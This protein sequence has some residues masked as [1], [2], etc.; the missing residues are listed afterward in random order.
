[1]I[2]ITMPGKGNVSASIYSLDG[3][4]IKRFGDRLLQAGA[5]QVQWDGRDGKGNKVN[6]GMYVVKVKVGLD[7]YRKNVAIVR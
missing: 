2:Q 3:R 6:A 1:M 5:H 4:L 7:I